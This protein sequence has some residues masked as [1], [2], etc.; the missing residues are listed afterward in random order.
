[1][2]FLLKTSEMLVE[3]ENLCGEGMFAGEIV[4]SPDAL[5]PRV[6]GHRAIIRPELSARKSGKPYS[7]PE[8]LNLD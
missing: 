2:K 8:I 3:G 5:L 1:M 4:G 7:N 6:D